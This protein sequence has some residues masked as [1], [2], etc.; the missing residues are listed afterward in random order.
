MKQLFQIIGK[1]TQYQLV[2][3]IIPAFERAHG[4]GYQALIMVDNSQGHTAYATDA[5]LTSQMNLRPGGKQARLRDGW[6]M[7]GGERVNQSMVFPPDHPE[8]PDMP[9]GMR[10]VLKEC[11]L[12]KQWLLMEC[13]DGCEVEATSC[14]AKRIL[15]LQSDFKAQKSLVQ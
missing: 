13:K 9:K 6:F 14:C 4:P 2:E 10:Q 15:D 11:G 3:K 8:F 1:L 12:W 7:R 5:L